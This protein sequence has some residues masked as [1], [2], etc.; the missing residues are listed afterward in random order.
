MRLMRELAAVAAAG[1]VF[2]IAPR[3]QAAVV[4]TMTEVGSNVVVTA[5]GTINLAGF[6]NHGYGQYSDTEPGYNSCWRPR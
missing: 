2:A 6:D 1:L 5:S 4:E 3:A